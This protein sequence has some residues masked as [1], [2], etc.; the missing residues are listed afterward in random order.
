MPDW[1]GSS[2]LVTGGTGFIGRH[3]VASL[4][5]QGASV[6]AL[7]RPAS[8]TPP[9]WKHRVECLVA[10]DWTAASLGDLLQGRSFEYLF[11][12]AAYGVKPG[13]RDIDAMLR[14]NVDVPATLVRMC[15]EWGATM[16]MAGSSAEYARAAP[17]H[18]LTETSPLETSKLYGSSKAAGGVM[19]SGMASELGVRL[20]LMRLFNVYGPGEA[21]HRLLP[22]LVSNLPKAKRV[23][24]SA[25]TQTRDFLYVSD[26]VDALLFA[27][28]L[29]DDRRMPVRVFNVCTGHGHSVRDFA[30][31]IAQLLGADAELL[32]FSDLPLR[33]DEFPWLVGDGTSLTAAGWSF[34]Y[35]LT[36]GLQAALSA[37]SA[38]GGHAS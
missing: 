30:G 23:A 14:M 38:T 34:R 9:E 17:G 24:L 35:D 26:A 22:A 36:A 32:G 20:R 5:E 13:D 18:P 33:P 6:I 1:S 29:D 15:A 12:L 19:V 4:L 3:L 27:S 7:V 2:V 25:G 31:R 10:D 8:A 37:A 28:G 11:H 16:V 21:P